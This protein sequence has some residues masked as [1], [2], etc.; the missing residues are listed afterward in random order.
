M[1]H[2]I[3]R[4]LALLLV[5][6]STMGGT[7]Q[8]APITTPAHIQAAPA[9]IRAVDVVATAT[10]TPAPTATPTYH[11]VWYTPSLDPAPTPAPTAKVKRLASAPV[12]TEAQAW[13]YAT[14]GAREYNALY[15][16]VWFESKWNPAAVNTYGGACGLG[17][18][19][20]CSK[21]SSLVPDWPT[22]P[23]GQLRLWLIP[24]C[25]QK[26]GTFVNAW[27]WETIHGG[28]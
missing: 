25:H 28:W 1:H 14:L 26:F 27:A 19:W 24:Y 2:D 6:A 10:P 5:A 7:T 12:T 11:A 4:L 17:Q 15:Q 22:N 20:P 21:L 23:I 8:T 3:K 13:A 16:I 9:P 18:S